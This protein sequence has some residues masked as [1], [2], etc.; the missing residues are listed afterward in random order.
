MVFG[1]LLSDLAFDDIE[2]LQRNDVRESVVLEYTSQFESGDAGRDDVLKKVSA[3]ANTFGGY[4]LFGIEEKGRQGRGQIKSI[5]GVDPIP[6]LKQTLIQWAVG[7][8]YPPLVD[9]EVS[10]PIPVGNQ[11]KVCYVV[12]VPASMSAPHFLLERGGCHVRVRVDEHS[13]TFEPLLAKQD[14]IWRLT[15]RRKALVDHRNEIIRTATK[16]WQ[17]LGTPRLTMYNQPAPAILFY[18]LPEFPAQRVIEPRGL[19]PL[20][21]QAA[22][23]HSR[24]AWHGCSWSA[25]QDTIVVRGSAG[26]DPSHLELTTWGSLFVAE[27]LFLEAAGRT[28]PVCSADV[29]RQQ[30][31]AYPALWLTFLR[32]LLRHIGFEAGVLVRVELRHVRGIPIQDL[33]PTWELS[34]KTEKLEHA[35]SLADDTV[36]WEETLSAAQLQSNLSRH[37]VAVYR[38]LAFGVGCRDA[39]ERPGDDEIMQWGC[40]WLGLNERDLLSA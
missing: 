17:D 31:I 22:V 12:Y 32:N 4:L 26:R 11:N 7:W 35:C 37:A 23:Q 25:Q 6:N 1:K 2:Q 8:V 16:R 13:M 38:R 34:R 18:A 14:E 29:K 28:G 19:H 21:E 3:F 39:Y 5:P 15:E 20:L 24:W 40:G 30:L 9:I 27:H 10:D 33:E 36:W